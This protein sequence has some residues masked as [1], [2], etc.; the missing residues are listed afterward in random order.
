MYIYN[1]HATTDADGVP[2]VTLQKLEM[3]VA[4]WS[5]FGLVVSWAVGRLARIPNDNFTRNGF[6]IPVCLFHNDI[7]FCNC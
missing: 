4:W 1:I 2:C 7:F 6:D 5:I 3:S